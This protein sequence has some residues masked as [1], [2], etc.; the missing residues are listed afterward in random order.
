MPLLTS[1][2]HDISFEL[3]GTGTPVLLISGLG[4]GGWV[5]RDVVGPLARH[6]RVVTFDNRGVGGSGKPRGPYSTRLLAEDAL[7]LL[8]GLG[9]PRA[10]V[11]GHSLGGMVAQELALLAP[12]RV[13]RLVLVGTTHGGK[14]AV[15]FPA[16]ALRVLTQRWG[17]PRVLFL[18]GLEE[19]TAPGFLARH[20]KAAEDV[21]QRRSECPV[22]PAGYQ[23]QLEAAAAHDSTA[24]LAELRTPTLLVHGSEDRMIPPANSTLLA[25]RLPDARVRLLP[26]VGHMVP[27]EAPA[28]LAD[29]VLTFLAGA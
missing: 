9:L 22:S 8:D 3:H 2:G 7:G 10:H 12:E 5:W 11:V 19:A 14:E 20:P 1:R 23:A 6:H 4:Y 18:Q 21:W 13:E 24:R 16:G 26:G 29:V 15:P 28:V 17:D 25:Q 27:L